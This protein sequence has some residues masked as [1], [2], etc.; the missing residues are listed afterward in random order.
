MEKPDWTRHDGAV[1]SL[2][3]YADNLRSDPLP[4]FID[5]CLK[6]TRFL[7]DGWIAPLD[8]VHAIHEYVA[9]VTDG[10][11]YI[12]RV[13]GNTLADNVLVYCLAAGAT[14]RHMFLD[15]HTVLSQVLLHEAD[16]QLLPFLAGCAIEIDVNVSESTEP[17]NLPQS[18]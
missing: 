12:S 14:Y 5:L 11:S 6:C 15:I 17:R 13:T 2:L 3:H 1:S 9:F 4:S 10:A 7:S 16:E 8:G 18:A